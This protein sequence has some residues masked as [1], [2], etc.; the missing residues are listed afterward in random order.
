MIGNQKF[1]TTWG[2]LV[3][4]DVSPTIDTRFD[5][6]SNGKNSHP[7]LNRAITPREAARIQ[8]FPDTFKFLGKKTEICKQIGN[9]V[10]PLLS[11]KLGESIN[12]QINKT[13]R[14]LTDSYKLF[15]DDAYDIVTEIENS[16][17]HIDHI[18]TDPP[19]N[20]SKNNNFSTMKNPR[21]GVDFGDWD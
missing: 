1:K 9:A 5:T 3:W 17:M 7:Y 10:P 4:D 18:I 19:Y 21:K 20:I 11:K 14:I 6:P 16:N 8:S 15:N 2:R 12:M 13:T